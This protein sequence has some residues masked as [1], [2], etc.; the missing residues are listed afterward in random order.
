MIISKRNLFILATLLFLLFV[1]FSYLV[2][3]EL[4]TQLDFD[5]TVRFQDNL[6]R[7][8]DAPFS[9]LSLLGMAEITGLIW[10]LVSLFLLFK[11]FYKAFFAM[12]LMPIGLALELFGKIYLYHPG[13]PFLFYRGTFDFDFPSHYVTA[14]YSY[15]SG[16]VFRTCFLIVFLM[17]YFYLRHSF[18]RQIFIQSFLAV[19]LI[20]MIISRIYLGEHWTTDVIGGFLLGSSF[21]LLAGIMVP[22][23]KKYLAS[24]NS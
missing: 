21:G 24:L 9:T 7:R 2:S 17:T 1:F 12:A 11:R 10:L 18:K 3:Q 4:F 16:H 13:P 6:S 19:I 23:K 15:P 20:L 8:L 5:T 14:N 22:I